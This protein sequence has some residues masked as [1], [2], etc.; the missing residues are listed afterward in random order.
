MRLPALDGFPLLLLSVLKSH[1]FSWPLVRFIIWMYLLVLAV[2]CLECSGNWL[3]WVGGGCT[4]HVDVFLNHI[5]WLASL[6]VDRNP[7]ARHS[8]SPHCDKWQTHTRTDCGPSPFLYHYSVPSPSSIEQFCCVIERGSWSAW[9]RPLTTIKAVCHLS[10]R[11]L[12][13]DSSILYRIS[14][15][16]GRLG[17]SDNT[18]QLM[19]WHNLYFYL[20]LYST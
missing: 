14:Q 19:L 2:I 4:C 10:V 17:H 15:S 7:L 13:T 18:S 6:C 8:L 16:F 11:A 20:V 9:C 3:P 1:I 12:T 5:S